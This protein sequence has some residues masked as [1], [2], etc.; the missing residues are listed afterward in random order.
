MAMPL[1]RSSGS[2]RL[3]LSWLTLNLTDSLFW[4]QTLVNPPLAMAR[5]VCQKSFRRLIDVDLSASS[6]RFVGW[7]MSFRLSSAG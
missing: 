5:H 6:C 4:T 3:P 1:E 2:S 7:L